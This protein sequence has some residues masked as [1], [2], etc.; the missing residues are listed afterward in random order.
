MVVNEVLN[1]MKNN[2]AMSTYARLKPVSMSFYAE[3]ELISAKVIRHTRKGDS[4]VD[5]TLDDLFDLFV[6]AAECKLLSKKLPC[7][8]M[9]NLASI[10]TVCQ[11]NIYRKMDMLEKHLA[12]VH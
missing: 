9:E 8:A 6:I 5:L 12:T 11:D 4:K 1:F 10:P 3:K 7:S 2:C